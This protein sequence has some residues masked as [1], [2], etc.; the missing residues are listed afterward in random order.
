MRAK[1]SIRFYN[2]IPVRAR[3]SDD[4]MTWWYAATDII[5]ALLQSTNPRIYWNAFKNR[6]PELSMFCRQLKITAADGKQ[7]ETD[8][9]NQ[10]GITQLL[11]LLPAKKRVHFAD[12]I[13]G[14][15]DPVDEQ[16][17]RNAYELYENSL[18]DEAEAGTIK[19]LQQIH[20]FLFGGLYEFAGQIRSKNISKGGFF[21][22]NCMFFD[23]IFH[24][25]EAMPDHTAE[26]IIDKYVEMNIVH[27]FL[28]GNGRA[29]RIWLDQLLKVRIGKC[30]D[31]QQIDRKA[32]LA[33]MERSPYDSSDIKKLLLSA[34]TDKINDREIF[35]KGI[36]YSYY[37]ETIEE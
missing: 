20:A 32:Y 30:V 19:G 11:L 8:C 10:A 13:K 36:D 25:L 15:A 27:P 29:T 2:H 21:F 18:L 33:A 31:W 24:E 6:H 3:W 23:K 1:T 9:L 5:Q 14:M 37:Y 17:K 28:E 26:E 7:Y 4:D 35:M 16:S 12:W 34:L 22:A